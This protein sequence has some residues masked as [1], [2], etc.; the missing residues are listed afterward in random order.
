MRKSGI[1]FYNIITVLLWEVFFFITNVY[2]RHILEFGSGLAAVKTIFNLMFNI[3]YFSFLI[4]IFDRGKCV[5]SKYVFDFYE[6]FARRFRIK[7]LFIMLGIQIVFDLADILFEKLFPYEIYPIR[8]VMIYLNWTALFCIAAYTKKAI[9]VGVLQYFLAAIS[10]VIFLVGLWLVVEASTECMFYSNLY[11]ADSEPLNSVIKSCDF[12]FQLIAIILNVAVGATFISFAPAV[13][14]IEDTSIPNTRLFK[15]SKCVFRMMV[16]FICAFCLISIKCLVCP[17][18]VIANTEKSTTKI[19]TILKEPYAQSYSTK[20]YRADGYTEK[21][22][23][24]S[25]EKK[26]IM[27]GDLKTGEI[28]ASQEGSTIKGHITVSNSNGHIIEPLVYEI[29]QNQALVYVAEDKA[30]FIKFDDI[31]DAQEDSILTEICKQQLE[32]G[33]TTLFIYAVDYLLDTAPDFIRSYIERYS[34]QEFTEAEQQNISDLH[35]RREFFKELAS[36]FL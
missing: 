31:Y 13:D 17:C 7:K 12:K 21:T 24:Y 25:E 4:I 5:F 34:R 29:Y 35:Y 6:S 11:I 19:T 18:G 33:N 8:M 10:A 28:K 15:F 3:L 36:D 9:S 23:C 32:D 2:P 30:R 22:L 1:I 16:L 27:Y 20:I 14:E 26:I